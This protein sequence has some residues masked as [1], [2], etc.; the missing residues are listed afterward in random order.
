MQG[1]LASRRAILTGIVIGGAPRSGTTLLLSLLS[2]SAEVHAIPYETYALVKEEQD[3]PDRLWFGAPPQLLADRR[4]AAAEPLVA[5]IDSAA[6]KA[7]AHIF[8]FALA[9]GAL[10]SASFDVER[11]ST[12]LAALIDALNKSKP[13]SSKG[14]FLRKVAVSSTMGIGVRVDAGTLQVFVLPFAQVF[15]DG[16]FIINPTVAQLE[17]S[18]LDLVVAGLCLVLLAP[19]LLSV[20]VAILLDEDRVWIEPR[21]ARAIQ[22]DRAPSETCT[23]S[24]CRRMRGRSSTRVTSTAHFTSGCAIGTSGS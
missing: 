3:I 12:N 8:G 14:V 10:E 24:R 19:L 15:V 9:A 1:L 5:A 22:W 20:A 21:G 6:R 4:G 17:Y 7:N 18:D 11:L 23:D 13:A 16:K 2:S